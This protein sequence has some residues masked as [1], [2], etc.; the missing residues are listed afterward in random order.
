MVLTVSSSLPAGR[1]LAFWGLCCSA[2][3]F[4]WNPKFKHLNRGFVSHINGFEDW[5]KHQCILLVIRSLFYFVMR[6]EDFAERLPAPTR[7]A[8][9]FIL[10]F[11]TLVSCIPL[12]Q[13]LILHA[14]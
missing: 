5:Y 2:L 13:S 7:A 12:L 11:I 1:N 3:S 9:G 10:V 6:R 8:H 14:K 4:W